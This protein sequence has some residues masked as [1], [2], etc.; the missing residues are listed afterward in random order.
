MRQLKHLFTLLMLLGTTK[1]VFGQQIRFRHVLG[2]TGYDIGMSAQ[3]TFDGGYILCGSTTSVGSGN[4][5]IYVIKTDSL[6]IPTN[7]TSI[8]GISV[9]RGTCI[10]QTLDHGY[11]VLG[12][13]N[14]DGGLGGYD[15][16][17]IKLDSILHVKWKKKYGGSDWDFGN[18]IEQTSDG[19][20]IICGGTYSYGNGDEDYYLIKTDAVG[21]TL[22]TRTYG[23]TLSEEAK[24][25]V[26]TTDGG[27]ILTGSSMSK[28]TLG[29]FY[30]VKTNSIGD[31]LWT[32]T[33]GGVKLDLAYDIIQ[34]QSG[35]YAVA[36][37][38]QNLGSG[39][40]DGIILEITAAGK[41][42][43]TFVGG[44]KEDDSFFSVTQRSDGKIAFAGLTYNFGLGK[45]DIYFGMLGGDFNFNNSATFGSSGK[46]T[47]N[48]VA[49]AADGGFIVCGT[50]SG[51][52][53]NQLDDI[54]LVKTGSDGK[55]DIAEKVL[56]TSIAETPGTA[57]NFTVYPNPADDYIWIQLGSHLR[58]DATI[59][60]NDVMGRMLRQET[61][62]SSTGEK[63]QLDFGDL[64]NGFYLITITTNNS[65]F[66]R[67]I[68][69]KHE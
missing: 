66:S 18:C 49:C 37:E 55:A 36:G 47:A 27:Y 44:G 54:Y 5:D 45:S 39:K 64:N 67:P 61:I 19:G 2:N 31:T 25:V 29:D 20:Y 40:S 60:V 46:E 63:I 30:T 38:T 32:N 7:E 51:Y 41:S 6:G 42:D 65:T 35:A 16:C 15:I 69:V 68:I 10:R 58:S 56:V 53:R 14:E 50:T 24:A 28:D 57:T 8:G 48:S 33:F 43:R 34:I 1:V 52:F 13:T 11:V 21:D 26:Q 22:W 3:Q 4:T 17:A 9:D 12:Y 62:L 59:T 23:G